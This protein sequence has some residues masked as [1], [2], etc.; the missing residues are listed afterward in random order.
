MVSP[1]RPVE[2]VARDL[3]QAGFRVDQVLHAIGQVTGQAAPNLKRRLKS[4]RG[5]D[6]ITDTHKDFDIGP[7]GAPVS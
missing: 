3:K 1:S 4:I 7:P 6:D 2:E 5:V